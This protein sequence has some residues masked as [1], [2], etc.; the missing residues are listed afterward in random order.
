[1]HK[2]D[3]EGILPIDEVLG[4]IPDRVGVKSIYSFF[5]I[6]VSLSR[7]KYVVF[8]LKGTDCVI[9]GLKGRFFMLEKHRQQNTDKYHLNLYAIENN[10]NIMIT[11]DHIIPKS[12]G[13]ENSVHNLQP[14]CVECNR[15]KGSHM[16]SD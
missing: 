13:G 8:K 2:Y 10:R 3:R 14:M 15:K 11:Q 9:C 5:G 6:E 7:T 12:K 1:M 4:K 16:I